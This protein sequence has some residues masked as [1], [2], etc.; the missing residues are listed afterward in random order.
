MN[1]LINFINDKLEPVLS[2]F[3]KNVWISSISDA[4]M[5]IMPMI[6]VGSV[7]T[8]LGV[9][10]T[11]VPGLPNFQPISDFSF[12]LMGLFASFLV[13]YYI[14]EKQE[15]DNSKVIGGLL[16]VAF[17]LLLSKP[18]FT[19]EGFISLEFARLG[20][21]GMFVSILGG[22]F[23]GIVMTFFMKKGI[24]AKNDNIPAFVTAWFDL[25]LPVSVVLLAGWLITYVFGFDTFTIITNLLAPLFQ[26]SQTLF[27]FVLMQFLMVFFYAFGITTSWISPI[28]YPIVFAAIAENSA[29]VS[30]GLA[31]TNINTFEVII[32]F[33][34]IGGTGA[35]LMLNV[36][37]LFSKTKSVKALGKTLI[38]P[39]IMNINEPIVFASVAF[40]PILMIPL[41]INGLVVP[42]ITYIVLSLGWVAIP[43]ESFML[44]FLPIGVST[45]L[46]NYDI[47][48]LVLLAVLIA[49]TALIWYP[50]FKVYEKQMLNKE[51]E[52]VE[53]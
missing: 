20:A 35:T 21:G 4:L 17:Y 43:A 5:L 23:T 30:A 31:A 48:G 53:A 51:L 19:P 50:F 29:A 3:L 9:V 6:L 25:L 24:F 38:V 22:E 37:M 7:V 49:V 14:L 8:I 32:A 34:A 15:L 42:I 26:S 13:P 46:S 47:R 40:N 52:E 33:L 44:W 16:S 10:G 1:K 39:S 2:K 18:T 45:F 36:F 12:G 41:W 28:L 27:G 11:Y